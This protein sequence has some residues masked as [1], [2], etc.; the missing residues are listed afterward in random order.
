MSSPFP[1]NLVA[2]PQTGRIAW[3]FTAKGEHNVWIAD[4][5]N[6]EARQVTHYTSDDGQLISGL[7]WWHQY[8]SA[9]TQEDAGQVSFLWTPTGGLL[10]F[11]KLALSTSPR[12]LVVAQ[13]GGAAFGIVGTAAA[14]QLARWTPATGFELFALPTMPADT[15]VYVSSCSADGSAALVDPPVPFTSPEEVAAAVAR[16]S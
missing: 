12:G 8:A 13:G 6:F 11:P 2:A 16:L 5:P 15:Q 10:T 14:Y 4:A 3:Q 9:T 7:S 1:T